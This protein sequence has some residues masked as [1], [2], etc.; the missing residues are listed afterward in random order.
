LQ[1]LA[2]S[3]PTLEAF[4]DSKPAAG[5]LCKVMGTWIG[6]GAAASELGL[7][8]Q[9]V[10]NRVHSGQLKGTKGTNGRWQI[11]AGSFSSYAAGY[12]RKT[13]SAPDVDR[14]ER[15]LDALGPFD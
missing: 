4:P 2:L 15:K 14:I 11:D 8:T 3:F 13:R 6:V 1:N 5:K 7:S 12:V 10:R 9:A